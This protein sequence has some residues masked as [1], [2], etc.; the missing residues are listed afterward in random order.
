MSGFPCTTSTIGYGVSYTLSVHHHNPKQRASTSM[1]WRLDLENNPR[2]CLERSFLLRSHKEV[3]NGRVID[4]PGWT[5]SQFSRLPRISPS[6]LP[7]T[8]LCAKSP[9]VRTAP[10]GTRMARP[11][12]VCLHSNRTIPT[13]HM[14]NNR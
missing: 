7:L 9:M 5:H 4:H 12:S 10:Q 11:W 1:Q 3:N 8:M 13:T 14:T 6:A 2:M